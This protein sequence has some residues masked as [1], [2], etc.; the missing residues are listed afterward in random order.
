[1]FP[2]LKKH[3][4]ACWLAILIYMH[5][6]LINCTLPWFVQ[7]W[8][9]LCYWLRL[10]HCHNRLAFIRCWYLVHS[11]SWW[12]RLVLVSLV[13]C[14]GWPHIL[15]WKGVNMVSDFI[16]QN[17]FGWEYKP[18]SSVGQLCRFGLIRAVVSQP[19]GGSALWICL[20][21]AVVT[22]PILKW[23]SFLCLNKLGQ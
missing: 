19:Q 20:V 15:C 4:F 17:S 1:M 23:A 5:V 9:T 3:L 21:R 11:I 7:P 2:F 13:P 16:P 10:L 14:C 22:K 18:R 8:V 6:V 12:S